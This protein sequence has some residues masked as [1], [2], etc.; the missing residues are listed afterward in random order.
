MHTDTG[1]HELSCYFNSH[2]LVNILIYKMYM[3]GHTISVYHMWYPNVILLYTPKVYTNQ[4]L[5]VKE[6]NSPHSY[7]NKL[8]IRHRE[9][10]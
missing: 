1:N 6:S 4:R 3:G 2:Q 9:D 10:N 7:I 8:K 5:Q